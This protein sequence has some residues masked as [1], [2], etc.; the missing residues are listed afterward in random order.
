MEMLRDTANLFAS[1]E[2]EPR[3]AAVDM[4]AAFPQEGFNGLAT[5][6]FTGMTINEDFGGSGGGY[7]ELAVVIEELAAACG[8]T[9]TVFLTHVSL[10]MRPIYRFG[11]DIQKKRWLPR[12]TA[13]KAVG[14]F[15]LTETSTGSDALGL[16]TIAV[17]DGNNYVLNGAKCFITNG[18]VADIFVVFVTHNRA[19]G[20][21][22]ISALI[23]ERN[24]PGF[25]IDPQTGS[26]GMRG[27]STAE[28]S[29]ND[30]R[31]P[32]SNRLG[33]EGLG[34]TVALATLDS[35][36]ISLAA[37]CVGLAR[38]SYESAL[39]YASHR[40]TFGTHINS[41]QAIQF[42]I[43]DMATEI[44]AA[45][46]MTY[47]A[48]SLCD[49]NPPHTKEAAMAKLFAS[50]AAGRSVTNAVQIHGG[51]GYFKPSKV[52]RMY[53]D[54]RVTQIYEGT[55]EIQRLVIARSEITNPNHGMQT[56]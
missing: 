53:R 6:G 12:M 49:A 8:S 47:R 20:Y 56:A 4:S 37:Q 39:S 7:K 48:A 14:A 32:K 31:V 34:Y 45:R 3:A 19:L 15:A 40:Q 30:C 38:G 18:T 29:F 54:Q 17:S 52:E 46:L 25:T 1:K 33:D 51:A 26:M 35:S 42:M 24:T 22:G 11:T 36:R 9:S 43:A 5:L 16:E 28:L 50:E 13:G 41:H 55:S 27:S 21:S 10:G 2:L 23:I 44:D